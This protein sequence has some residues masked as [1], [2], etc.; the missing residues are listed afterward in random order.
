[1]H[2]VVWFFF[3]VCVGVGIIVVV[4]SNV[5]KC[6]GHVQRQRQRVVQQDAVRLAILYVC[7]FVFGYFGVSVF[8]LCFIFEC[9]FSWRIASRAQILGAARIKAKPSISC[10][11]VYCMHISDVRALA[12]WRK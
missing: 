12:A 7:G 10:I 11:H 9:S 1:M 3:L 8:V 6:G 2:S 4:P 5:R